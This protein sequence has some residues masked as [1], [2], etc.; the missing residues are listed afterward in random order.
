LSQRA[1]RRAN[2]SSGSSP[3][4]VN[5]IRHLRGPGESYSDVILRLAEQN[6]DRSAPRKLQRRAGLSRMGGCARR[7]GSAWR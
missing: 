3:T 6:P 7:A 5:K 1:T 2:A 4:V